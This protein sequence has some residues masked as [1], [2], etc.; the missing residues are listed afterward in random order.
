MPDGVRWNGQYL[1]MDRISSE[2][3]NKNIS[4]LTTYID[5]N[6]QLNKFD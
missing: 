4:L 5:L 6:N 1:T 3:F 2:V